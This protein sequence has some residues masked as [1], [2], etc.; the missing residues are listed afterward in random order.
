MADNEQ[1]GMT[2]SLLGRWRELS[3][4][5]QVVII[6]VS[7]A[8]LAFLLFMFQ[9]LSQPKYVTLYSNLDPVEA[10]PLVQ[11]L[12]EKGVP[13]RLDDFGGTIKVPQDRADELRIEMAGQGMP[14]AQ[15]LGFEIFDEDSLGMTSFERQV[16]MQRALQEELR[17]TITSLDAVMQAR[18]HLVLPEPSV[19]MRE[20]SEPS[21]AVYLKLN[22]FVALKQ[23]QIRG[24]VFL[25]ASSVENLKPENVIIIDSQGNILYDAVTSTDPLIAVAD[26]ALKQLE[27][28]RSF[29]MELENR[30]Q[31]MLERVFGPGRA[32]ALVTAELDFDSQETT[33]I[34]YDESGVPR[35]SHLLEE[36]FEGEGPVMEEVGESNYPG[37]VGVTPGGESSFER[38]EETI[39]YEIGESKQT[40][41]TAP[42]KVI[43]MHTSVVIDNGENFLG[44]DVIQQ[45][46]NLVSAA[47]GFD[48]ARGDLISVESMSFDRSFEEKMDTALAEMEQ[49]Q[50]REQLIRQAV[51]GGA[52]LVAFVLFM[53]L[54]RRRRRLQSEE[55]EAIPAD[56][57]PS[58]EQ[59]LALEEKEDYL[60]EMSLESSPQVRARKMVETHPEVAVSVLRSW[61]VEE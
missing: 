21:A 15:G 25:V 45:V 50:R 23:E 32:L 49:Q 22:P 38:R 33:V 12:R 61:M 19:F 34:T 6:I 54:W 31:G 5:R 4:P 43:R 14:F 37:Y 53:L 7:A 58:L 39:N 18:V 16:K 41:L 46:N 60:P 2:D 44:A 26:S 47:I 8:V 9:Y 29:E 52:V 11:Y 28:K 35:S 3:R 1:G 13:Y 20:S 57:R 48:A 27:V 40:T 59:L 24:I 10:S 55:E 17:R 42:G 51:L 56:R 30:V 36:S